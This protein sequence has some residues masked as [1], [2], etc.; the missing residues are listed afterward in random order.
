MSGGGA[1]KRLGKRKL[2]DFGCI[3][4]TIPPVPSQLLDDAEWEDGGPEGINAGHSSVDGRIAIN[5]L[6]AE[7]DSRLRNGFLVMSTNCK[8]VRNGDKFET[9][10]DLEFEVIHYV[11]ELYE[12]ILFESS[13]V[14]LYIMSYLQRMQ[15]PYFFVCSFEGMCIQSNISDYLFLF[16]CIHNSKV[17]I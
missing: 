12:V 14:I 16:L 2:G 4:T 10:D 15:S 5:K 3:D 8:S 9:R 6:N 11:T 13:K 7:I 1:Q 17:N